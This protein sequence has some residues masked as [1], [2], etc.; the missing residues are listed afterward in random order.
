MKK[1]VLSSLGLSVLTCIAQTAFAEDT[2][3]AASS[4]STPTANPRSDSILTQQQID[5][6]KRE[7][8][9]KSPTE[10]YVHPYGLLQGYINTTDSE[11]SNVPDFLG[12]HARAGL[13]VRG[14]IAS[15]QVEFEFIGNQ[16]QYSQA[17]TNAVSGTT[18]IPSS[19]NN[20][21]VLR[22]AQLNLDVFKYQDADSTYLTTVS[23]GG[24]RVGAAAAAAPDSANTT[25]G[26]SREDGVYVQEKMAFGRQL[27]LNAGLGAFNTMFGA[28]PGANYPGWGGNPAITM[29]NFWLSTSLNPSLGYVANLNTTYNFDD[30]RSLNAAVYY[31][32]QK[33][34]P[35]STIATPIQ[36][37]GS[38]SE[39]RDVNHT[40]ASLLY[41]DTNVFGTQGIISG[42]GVAAWY[43]REQNSK[44]MLVSGSLLGGYVYN[45]GIIDDAQVASLYGIG[46][47]ADTQKYLTNM[48]QVGDRLT[49]AA[50]YTLVTSTLGSAQNTYKVNQLALSAGYAVNTFEVALNFEYS[51]AD[52]NA[53]F[54]DRNGNPQ[55]SE[56]QSYITAT[57]VF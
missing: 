55:N 57:Y 42:N 41:N 16:S 33:N 22:Q 43:E 31:G 27:T 56:T 17:Q 30:A 47:A 28:A 37:S 25:S 10:N 1:S 50:A 38:L 18:Y 2:Q 11:R 54:S 51:N 7:L 35:Y 12:A 14:G 48:L 13:S 26:F 39:A 5:Q 52:T 23:F 21:V 34:A 8:D 45:S 20:T 46:V 4:P 24:I 44:T 9:K 6:I 29:Q 36:T 19:T 3:V 53:F 15:G 49:G 40:E 32:F